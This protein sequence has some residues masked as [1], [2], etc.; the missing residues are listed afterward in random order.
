ML[1]FL[2]SSLS[3][4]PHF[5][6]E[7]VDVGSVWAETLDGEVWR[8]LSGPGSPVVENC[9]LKDILCLILTGMFDVELGFPP[10]QQH[11]WKHRTGY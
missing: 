3:V 6:I 7:R 10:L 11:M 1:T 4:T 2:N 8:Q 9:S 5:F